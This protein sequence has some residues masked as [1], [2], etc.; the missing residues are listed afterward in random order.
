MHKLVMMD[1][2]FKNYTLDE[3]QQK[4]NE[5]FQMVKLMGGKDCTIKFEFYDYKDKKPDDLFL[6]GEEE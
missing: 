2:E 6:D 1:G 4:L 3:A 5:M